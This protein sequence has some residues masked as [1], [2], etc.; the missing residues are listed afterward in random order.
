MKILGIDPG[1]AIVGYSVLDYDGK[2][3]ELLHSGSVQTKKGDRE[4]TRL[5][6]IFNDIL[7]DL[8]N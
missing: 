1:L 2:N 5:L 7:N 8:F 4:S 3:T 6:E